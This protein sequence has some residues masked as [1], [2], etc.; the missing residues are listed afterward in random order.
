[1]C[2]MRNKSSQEEL[3]IC[4]SCWPIFRVNQSQLIFSLKFQSN[5]AV[6]GGIYT[7]ALDMLPTCALGL[8][9]I[10]STFGLPFTFDFVPLGETLKGIDQDYYQSTLKNT[11]STVYKDQHVLRTFF[12]HNLV[13]S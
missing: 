2:K 13:F 10:C 9:C 4:L 12:G 3:S 8:F 6:I 7:L 1:M 11:Y 5:C